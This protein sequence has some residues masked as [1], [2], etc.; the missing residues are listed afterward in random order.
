M[1][2]LYFCQATIRIRGRDMEKPA[3]KVERHSVRFIREQHLSAFEA[4]GAQGQI[5]RIEIAPPAL[6]MLQE[7]R[8]G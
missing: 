4:E 3:D 7:R 5:E 8:A 6:E 1:L 2:T